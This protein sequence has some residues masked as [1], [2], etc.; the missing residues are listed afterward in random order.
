MDLFAGR[1]R[2]L[3]KKDGGGGNFLMEGGRAF[4]ENA[5]GRASLGCVTPLIATQF[6]M[7]LC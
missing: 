7:V 3:R 4:V 6:V 2:G 5:L 1:R